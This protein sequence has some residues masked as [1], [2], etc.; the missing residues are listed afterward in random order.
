M[1]GGT[2]IEPGLGKEAMEEA[3][4]ECQRLEAALAAAPFRRVASLT[5]FCRARVHLAGAGVVSAL[6]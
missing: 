1:V 3:D 6:S 4:P 5:A 2:Q